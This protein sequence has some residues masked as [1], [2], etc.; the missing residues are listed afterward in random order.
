VTKK[1]WGTKGVGVGHNGMCT[2]LI[3]LMFHGFIHKNQMY[4]V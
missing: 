3:I 2:M 1:E 4:V